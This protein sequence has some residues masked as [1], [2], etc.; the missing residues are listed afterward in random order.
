[1]FVVLSIEDPTPARR[2]RRV[3]ASDI[4]GVSAVIALMVLLARGSISTG[5]LNRVVDP[6][7]F[8]VPVLAAIVL[9]AVVIRVVPMVVRRRRCC[10]P[11]P[12]AGHE[13][14]AGGGHRPAA[15][16]DRHGLAHCGDRDVR[17]S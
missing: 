4:V 7:L 5:S 9:A 12:V 1:M 14:D 16:I 6:T 2:N 15:A 3:L 13:A 11:A 8:A 17:V 10:Q